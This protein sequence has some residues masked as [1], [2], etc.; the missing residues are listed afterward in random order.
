[1]SKTDQQT[2]RQT[3]RQVN[4]QK[5]LAGALKKTVFAP[6][7]KSYQCQKASCVEF[8]L[9]LTFPV[10]RVGGWVVGCAELELKPTNLQLPV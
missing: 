5:L 4:P 10:W 8:L 7:D 2:D 1:M 6:I 3:D 9:Y